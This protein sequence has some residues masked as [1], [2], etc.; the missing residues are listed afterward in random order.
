MQILHPLNSKSSVSIGW[1]RDR[2]IL[3]ASAHPILDPKLGG[4]LMLRIS[5]SEKF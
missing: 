3:K 5:L 2:L 1:C 4:F